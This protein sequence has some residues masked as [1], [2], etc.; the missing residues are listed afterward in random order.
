VLPELV[1]PLG[2]PCGLVD[3]WLISPQLADRLILAASFLPF[4]LQ[5]ISGNRSP[6]H[7]MKLRQEGRP[8]ADVDRSTHTSCPA[9]GADVWPSVAATRVVQAT[10]GEALVR[11]GLRWGGGSPVDPSTGIP[12]DWNH[13][14]LG[15]RNV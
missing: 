13:A 11:A 14:D 10:L 2:D 5:I 1:D 7:Q 12:S 15:P 4:S 9:T 8:T 6:A 3:R